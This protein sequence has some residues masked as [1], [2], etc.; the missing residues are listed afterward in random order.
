MVLDLDQFGGKPCIIHHH[1]ARQR[2][3][4]FG[5]HIGSGGLGVRE[6][7]NTGRG[8]PVQQQPDHP[9]HQH[10]GLARTG[11]GRYP[12]REIG[13]GSLLLDFGGVLNRCEHGHA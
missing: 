7:E 5:G 11:I 10:M 6:R 9:L 4:H 2:I 1:P 12:D 8:D 3:E 13:I